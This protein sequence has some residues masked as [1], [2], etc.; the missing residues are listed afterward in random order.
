M[1]ICL[2]PRTPTRSSSGRWRKR[3]IKQPTISV[4]PTPWRRR[5]DANFAEREGFEPSVQAL[6]PYNGL[7]N[8]RLRPTRPPLQIF[9]CQGISCVRGGGGIR[10]LGG[11][12][13]SSVFKTDAFD[14]SA[15]PP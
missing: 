15:T 2:R 3:S 8:R 4:W 12:A 9:S 7:A 5:L 13:P 6:D 14:H 1:L 11:V 10:T